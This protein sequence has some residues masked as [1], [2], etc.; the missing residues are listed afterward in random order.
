[1]KILYVSS[2][3][4]LFPAGGIGT[5]ISFAASAMAAMGHSV[6]LLTWT[7]E[8]REIVSYAPFEPERVRIVELDGNFVWR[9]YPD[10]PYHIAFAHILAEQINKCVAEWSIDVVE[11][12]DFQSPALGFYRQHQGSSRA[13]DV[14]CVTYNHGLLEQSYEAARVGVSMT[15]AAE[16]VGE[17]EQCRISDLVVA[18]S[19]KAKR[20]LSQYGISHNCEIIREPYEFKIRAPV[21]NITGSLTDVG[22]V[23]IAKGIDRFVLAATLI[24]SIT[25]IDRI[26]LIGQTVDTP[27]RRANIE[28]YIKSRLPG[29]LKNSIVFT[30]RLSREVALTFLRSGDIAPSLSLAETFS[31]TFVETLDRGLIPIIEDQSAVYEFMPPDMTKYAL[32]FRQDT[33][34]HLKNKLEKLIENAPSLVIEMQEYNHDL[35]NPTNIAQIMT[36]KYDYYL[37]NKKKTQYGWENQSRVGVN[38]DD[39]TILMPVHC[40]SEHLFEAVDSIA[41]QSIGCPKVIICDDGTPPKHQG[42]LDYAPMR[43]PNVRIHRQ[44]NMGLLAARN[45][46]IDECQTNLAVFLDDDDIFGSTFLE[47]AMEA[48]KFHPMRPNAVVCPRYNFGE[49]NEIVIRNNMHD[50]THLIENDFRMTCLI[51][52]DVLRDIR[53]DISVRNGEGDDWAFWVDFSSKGYR[54]VMIHDLLFHYR[55]KLGSMSWPWS[56]GQEIGT[57]ILLRNAMI[58]VSDESLGQARLAEALYAAK[59]RRR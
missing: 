2:E 35:L 28:E 55:F 57:H 25:K 31:Y 36:D 20:T 56:E 47:R 41:N 6:F 22:R 33:Q 27:Y 53:F 13:S 45:F 34:S 23:S 38:I 9:N 48:Y 32:N 37:S 4:P 44:P 15:S 19:Q 26:L 5:Y 58:N 16:L 18:P 7:Y 59:I 43:L 29:E 51:E 21:E 12:C 10:G 52:T 39:V 17:R 40:T 11:A 1:M 42:T 54:A 8:S 30:G 50:H 3:S 24:S 14:L 46:L 49:S